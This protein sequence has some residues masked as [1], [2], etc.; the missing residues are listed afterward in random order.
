MGQIPRS[1]ERIFS[2]VSGCVSDVAD[3]LPSNRLQLTCVG[4]CQT[5][6]QHCINFAASAISSRRPSSSRSSLPWFCVDSTMVMA[7][8]LAYRTT[9]STDSSRYRTQRRNWYSVDLT[10]SRMQLSLVSL[11]WLT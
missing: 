2:S 4:R 1:I 10:T 8:W 5:V 6:S 7:H 9:L 11:H 3:W